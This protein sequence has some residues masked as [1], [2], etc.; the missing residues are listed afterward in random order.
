MRTAAQVDGVGIVN[1]VGIVD[2]AIR[3]RAGDRAA[4]GELYTRLA[5]SVV[6]AA[7]RVVSDPEV[8]ADVVQD[9]FVKALER[10]DQLRDVERFAAWLAGIARNTAM[11]ALRAR[12]RTT[13]DDRCDLASLED[14]QVGPEGCVESRRSLDAVM[15]GVGHLSPNDALA[16]TLV[17]HLGLS[18]LELAAALGIAPT[19][20][21][22]RLHRARRRLSDVVAET[23]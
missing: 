20:A 23:R 7:R 6:A 22:V 11:D 14:T 17:A 19:A 1:G 10:L 4:Y 3:A 9:T 2:L 18:T 5:P 8:V 21:K 12:Y 16:L 13:L 15:D